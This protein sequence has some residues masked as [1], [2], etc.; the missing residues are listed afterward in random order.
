M[1][2]HIMVPYD[3]SEPVNRALE[4]AMD[5]AKKYSS[6]ISIVACVSMNVSYS[7]DGGASYV[8]MVKLQKKSAEYDLSKLE[9]KLQELK[10]PYCIKAI[11]GTSITETLISYAEIHHVNLIVMGSRGLGGFKK[12]LL[13]SVTSGV[14]QHSKCPM[15]IVK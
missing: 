7:T 6:K 9:P 15:W 13:G 8:E 1:F 11:E 2:E 12:L 5:L 3:K 14:L 4:Y 10:I